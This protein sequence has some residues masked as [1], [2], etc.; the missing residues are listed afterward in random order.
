MNASPKESVTSGVNASGEAVPKS[1][2]KIDSGFESAHTAV[3]A[4]FSQGLGG[5]AHPS[6]GKIH[7]DTES[8]PV[9]EMDTP[10]EMFLTGRKLTVAVYSRTHRDRDTKHAEKQSSSTVKPSVPG[11]SKP[12]LI[13]PVLRAEVVHPA[14]VV[15]TQSRGPRIQVSCFDINMAGP[16]RTLGM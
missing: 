16:S 14:F 15:N 4:K 9:F 5:A 8:L 10:W 6:Q 13:K 12:S 3:N 11:R 2:E 7:G 1:T